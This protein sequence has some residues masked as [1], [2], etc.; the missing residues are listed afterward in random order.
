MSRIPLL[1][2]AQNLYWVVIH[3]L[4]PTPVEDDWNVVITECSSLAAKWKQLSGYLGLPKSII[5]SIKEDYHNDNLG[6]WNEALDRWIKQTYNTEKFGVPS[7][8]TLLKAVA[9]VDKLLFKDLASKH[10][11]TCNFFSVCMPQ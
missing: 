3:S 10:Q 9:I 8:R 4:S 5:D 11:G 1:V 7:W 6:C 2:S